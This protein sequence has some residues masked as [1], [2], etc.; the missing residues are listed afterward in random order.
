PAIRGRRIRRQ[1]RG[2]LTARSRPM[3]SKAARVRSTGRRTRVRPAAAT[4]DRSSFQPMTSC[5]PGALRCAWPAEFGGP[6]MTVRDAQST[7]LWM[8]TATTPHFPALTRDVSCDV[9][10]VGAG[11]A[12]VTTA[13]LLAKAGVSV[14]LLEKGRIG[15]GQTERTTAHLSNAIDAW[16]FEIE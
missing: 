8:A 7:S 12:G 1:A 5:R 14:V 11:I 10:V 4:S 2:R 15:G 9:C 6:P 13:W 3:R 16:Y